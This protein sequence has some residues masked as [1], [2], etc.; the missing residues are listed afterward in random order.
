MSNTN[1]EFYVELPEGKLHVYVRLITPDLNDG[2]THLEDSYSKVVC[3][4]LIDY[5]GKRY[6]VSE[7]EYNLFRSDNKDK[8][9]NKIWKEFFYVTGN[10]IE[11]VDVKKL[12]LEEKAL[13]YQRTSNKE[14]VGKAEKMFC[15]KDIY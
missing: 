13:D 7:T 2:I 3:V 10:D 11:Q 12:T 5:A 9:G 6:K 1:N 14:F 8:N 4:D 15:K